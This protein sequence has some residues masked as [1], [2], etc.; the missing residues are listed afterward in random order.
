[1]KNKDTVSWL[2]EIESDIDNRVILYLSRH[3]EE[4]QALKK[5]AKKIGNQYYDMICRMDSGEGEI[6]LSAEEHRAYID[7]QQ[8]RFDF[9]GIE[10][11]Y[12]YLIGQADWK[13]HNKL[14]EKLSQ[15]LGEEPG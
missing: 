7:Y 8:L 1:M 2:P 4:Y 12:Y 9:E 10:R 3:H 5:A 14:L 15:E 6:T 11:Q 13:K